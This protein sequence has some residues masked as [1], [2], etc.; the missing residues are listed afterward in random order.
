MVWH[1]GH[2]YADSSFMGDSMPE[3][4]APGYR[5]PYSIQP[6]RGTQSR[7]VGNVIVG[8]LV[9]LVTGLIMVLW[10][11]K[12]LLF[13]AILI[14]VWLLIMGLL[15][16]FQAIAGR[17]LGVRRRLL[18]GMAGGLYLVI[19]AICVG[20]VFASLALLTVIVGLVWIVGGAAE[21]ATGWPRFWPVVFGVLTMIAGVVVLLWPEPTLKAITVLVGIWFMMIGVIQLVLALIAYLQRR[22]TIEPP[23]AV[24]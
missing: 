5:A 6:A 12:T 3:K 15:R 9:S 8:G 17:E 18:L 23:A 1:T 13:V 16:L 2:G 4:I 21:A 20:D 19:G 24:A 14:G 7:T 11:G 22:R 10:P